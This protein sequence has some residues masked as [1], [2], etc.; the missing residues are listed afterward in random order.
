MF[1]EQ[2]Q[3]TAANPVAPFATKLLFTRSE[4][5]ELLSVSV[6]TIDNLLA[7]KELRVVRI[8]KSVRIPL[9]SLREFVRRDH[10]T[11]REV[12]Q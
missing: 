6:R 1:A 11:S 7:L 2:S 12:V 10:S 3:N 8:G 5:A 4:A 9:G